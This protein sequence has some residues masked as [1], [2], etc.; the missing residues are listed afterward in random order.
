LS[1]NRTFSFFT[2]IILF[3]ILPVILYIIPADY[4]D[5]GTTLCIVKNLTD[6]DCPGCGMT[7][8]IFHLIHF[9]YGAAVQY[10]KGVVVVLPLLGFLWS[11]NFFRIINNYFMVESRTHLKKRGNTEMPQE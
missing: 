4:F 8:A 2:R 10:N 11:Q 7:R 6:H 1:E 3:L 5:F 9:E